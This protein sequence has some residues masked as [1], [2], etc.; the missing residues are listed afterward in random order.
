MLALNFASRTELEDLGLSNADIE[1]FINL[2][3]RIGEITHEKIAS[4]DFSNDGINIL[5][6]A[7]SAAIEAEEYTDRTLSKLELNI[8][9][10]PP[11]ATLDEMTIVVTYHGDIDRELRTFDK[12]F[13]PHGPLQF[14]IFEISHDHI[15]KIELISDDVVIDTRIAIPRPK[16]FDVTGNFEFPQW[17]HMPALG[18][19][20]RW[21]LDGHIFAELTLTTRTRPEIVPVSPDPIEDI[22]RKGRFIVPGMPDFRFDGYSFSFSFPEAELFTKLPGLFGDGQAPHVARLEPNDPV[23]DSIFQLLT[24]EP[25]AVDFDG[26]F[27]IDVS[28]R[29]GVEAPGWAW[30]L[31][32][33]S[34]YVGFQPDPDLYASRNEVII[35][36][37][38]GG[39]ENGEG[40]PFNITER[41]MLDRPELFGG[42]AGLNCRPF[43]QPGRI[44][45]ERRLQTALRVTQ[46]NVEDAD[47]D[48]ITFED[49]TKRPIDFPRNPVSDKIEYEPD[50]PSHYQAKTVS[51]GHL[52]ETAVRYRSNG[53]SLGN[54]AYSLTLAPRQKR[55]IV[56]VDYSRT[57]SAR[58][59]E[60]TRAEDEVADAVDS[61]RRY[62]N[63]VAASLDEWSRGRSRASTTAG[64]GGFGFAVPFFAMGGGVASSTSKSSS[65]QEGGRRTAAS[66]RQQINDSVRRYGESLRTLQSTVIQ[67]VE[68]TETVEGVSEVVQNINH[69]RSLSVIYYE[70]LRHL[71]VDT[72]IA[73]VT[74]C[75]YVPMKV[76]PFD[77]ERIQRYKDVL[78]RY[79]RNHW[80]RLAFRNLEYLPDKLGESDIPEGKRFTQ[81]LTTLSGSIWV[82]I[83][84]EMPTVGDIAGEID[85]ATDQEIT[86]E[87][88][89]F[90]LYGPYTSYLPVSISQ[91]VSK[92]VSASPE[93]RNRYFQRELAPHMARHFV[94]D[95]RISD[96]DGNDLDADFTLATNY[97]YGQSVRVDFTVDLNDSG[98]NREM[99]KKLTLKLKSEFFDSGTGETEK[100]KQTLPPRSFMNVTRGVIR[101]GNDFYDDTA[102][103]DR[104]TR[105][106]VKSVNGHGDEK[107]A[108]LTFRPSPADERDLQNVIENAYK[109]FKDRIN[110]RPFF[111]HKAIWW[112]M[113]RDELYTL[114]DGHSFEEAGGLSLASIV[115]RRPLGILGNTLIFK[116]STD[117]PLDPMFASFED[118]RAHYVAGLPPSDPIRV[119]LPTD[120]LYARAHMDSCVAAEEHN[121]SFDWVFDNKEPELAGLPSSLLE[122]RRSQTPDLTP[123]RFP[124]TIINLQNAPGM[125]APSGLGDALNAVTKGD[126]FRDMAG[127]AGTQAN[128]RAGLSTAAGLATSFGGMAFQGAMAQLQADANAASDLKGMFSAIEKARDSG[129]I[130]AEQ[131]GE[132][133]MEVAKRRAQGK[134]DK[135]DQH[136][137]DMEKEAMEGEGGGSIT[138]TDKDGSET[139]T[140]NPTPTSMDSEKVE[141]PSTAELDRELDSH[142]VA[143]LPEPQDGRRLVA[144]IFFGTREPDGDG[145]E[146]QLAALD[147]GDRAVLG[148]LRNFDWPHVA[149]SRWEVYGYADARGDS[150]GMEPDLN[151]KLSRR[152]AEAV[153]G[154]LTSLHGTGQNFGE[155]IDWFIKA[156][157]DQDSDPNQPDQ[158]PYDRRVDIYVTVVESDTNTESVLPFTVQDIDAHL[159]RKLTRLADNLDRGLHT[160]SDMAMTAQWEIKLYAAA[161]ELL[162]LLRAGETPTAGGDPS[163]VDLRNMLRDQRS[164]ASNLEKVRKALVKAGKP[165]S[166]RDYGSSSMRLVSTVR[167][168]QR[169]A[170]N[171]FYRLIYLDPLEG[172]DFKNPPFFNLNPEPEDYPDYPQPFDDLPTDLQQVVIDEGVRDMYLPGA[173]HRDQ[174][175]PHLQ[176]REQLLNEAK[177]RLQIFPDLAD[178]VSNNPDNWWMR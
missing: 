97:S 4:G 113:D 49:P 8:Q 130:T 175:Q 102:S 109:D 132:L 117:V 154:Y 120:G 18:E 39:K 141:K 146:E 149:E 101:Y 27:E 91:I 118:L 3:S 140:K 15:I 105:D 29:P 121:G 128:T 75:V 157:G 31:M 1:A 72:E 84:I 136:R 63:V 134:D 178:A 32:G 156:N 55:R 14:A 104:G 115:S 150:T 6:R 110:A 103:S 42:D 160:P 162:E 89:L 58:R 36:L 107:G 176:R 122:S 95:L 108:I 2:R 93:V 133:A 7:F 127:L 111:Y 170:L 35:S 90:T 46:P 159:Q 161:K 138:K 148:Q 99:L 169:L 59:R 12:P 19:G 131:A 152:R 164:V 69:T 65:S 71:R 112:N 151:E 9:P 11:I 74:E 53:Y 129:L 77:D 16:Q 116:V 94:D 40:V 135:E 96:T 173:D 50:D 30:I 26:M 79:A 17:R 155:D 60:T 25:G 70:I 76:S 64:A 47:P 144:Q 85:E 147:R 5:E 126:S 172:K 88:K 48:P 153:V 177:T 106:L 168:Q 142:L 123:T 61:S 28:N 167:H 139:V 124:E 143:E 165:A 10:D 87:D 13:L 98:L 80:E 100:P 114:L 52:L 33:S 145:V 119:S 20:E 23:V 41:G 67:E 51:I 54:I 24:A 137:R 171:P 43:D 163:E 92:T 21:Y 45:G 78:R 86:Y 44:L 22:H 158:F 82:R 166:F 73:G 125:P 174:M 56:K 37:P 83:G 81:P 38:H 62:D 68:Q 57:E 66:E 34:I